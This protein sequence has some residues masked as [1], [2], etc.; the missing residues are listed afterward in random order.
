MGS[1]TERNGCRVH[2]YNMIME[3]LCCSSY[4]PYLNFASCKLLGCTA[5]SVLYTL[6]LSDKEI[7]TQV[8][9]YLL[10]AFQARFD[11]ARSASIRRVPLT[12][13]ISSPKNNGN[14]TSSRPSFENV[15]YLV[16]TIKFRVYY[17]DHMYNVLRRRRLKYLLSV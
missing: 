10:V 4:S 2:D 9:P 5:D 16:D 8:A 1:G 14:T 11:Q 15:S 6:S 13:L 17:F 12:L 3:K 7:V